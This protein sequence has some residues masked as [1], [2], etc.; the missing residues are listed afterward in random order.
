MF[1]GTPRPHKG[2]EDL[3]EAIKLLKDNDVLLVVVGVQENRYSQ[4]LVKL[5]KKTIGERFRE[6]GLQPFEKVPEFLAAADVV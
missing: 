2:L 5:G 3:I 4:H 1:L 6:F